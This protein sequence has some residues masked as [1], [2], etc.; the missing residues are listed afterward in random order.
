MNG[1]EFHVGL[2]IGEGERDEGEFGIKGLRLSLL[3]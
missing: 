2:V 1:E 3:P